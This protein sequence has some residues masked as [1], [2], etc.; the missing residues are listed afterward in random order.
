MENEQDSDDDGQ[1]TFSV[2]P[3]HT[4]RVQD[5]RRAAP[6]PRS[7]PSSLL[8]EDAPAAGLQARSLSV[9]DSKCTGSP[10]VDI[11]LRGLRRTAEILRKVS[12][13]ER[14]TRLRDKIMS[15][16]SGSRERSPARDEPSDDE[17]A[18]LVSPTGAPGQLSPAPL[19]SPGQLAP[20]SLSSPGPTSEASTV[21][22]ATCGSADL[23]PRS[24]VT[25]LESPHDVG[26]AFDLLPGDKGARPAR[27]QRVDSG[28]SLGNM[29]EP[30][31]MRLLAH[32][33]VDSA[34]AL[35]RQD[36]LDAGPPW[37]WDEPDSA[38]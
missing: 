22:G 7:R 23:S 24:D 33:T 1:I 26:A 20:A 31:N 38:V 28:A 30:Y 18:P 32:G 12:S 27:L 35:W 29:V 3:R 5:E 6:A 25:E 10:V 15:R 19:G 21:A 4:T 2:R 11:K 8:V 9:D 16:G 36:A 17:S 13:A 34:R 14:L 37:P